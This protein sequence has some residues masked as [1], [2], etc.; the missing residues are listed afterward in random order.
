MI[1]YMLCNDHLSSSYFQN[2]N[3]NSMSMS[4]LA[5]KQNKSHCKSNILFIISNLNHTVF[6]F[7]YEGILR[8]S[9][10]IK[11]T[12]RLWYVPA[13]SVVKQSPVCWSHSNPYG[14]LHS[15]SQRGPKL[16]GGQRSSQLYL[17]HTQVKIVD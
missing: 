5:T 17:K 11:M 8:W 4:T 9:N 1:L 15:Y 16:P 2:T 7:A 10:R 14:H 13:S 3:R 6:I 12:K